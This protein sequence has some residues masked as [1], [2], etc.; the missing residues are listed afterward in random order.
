MFFFL[1]FFCFFFFFLRYLGIKGLTYT[2]T[3]LLN[4]ATACDGESSDS[5]RSNGHTLL[6][7]L[8]SLR[9]SSIKPCHS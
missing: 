4:S 5:T 1:C 7:N 3:H 8:L 9:F 2:Q 6:K